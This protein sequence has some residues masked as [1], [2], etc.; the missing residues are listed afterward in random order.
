VQWPN[1]AHGLGLSVM[2]AC[3]AGMQRPTSAARPIQGGWPTQ[4]LA[5]RLTRAAGAV[6]VGVQAQQRLGLGHHV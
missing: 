3:G 6:E 1:L 2:A 5:A 4:C